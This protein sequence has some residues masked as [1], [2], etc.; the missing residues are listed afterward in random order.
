M[1]Q[2]N[3]RRRMEEIRKRVHQQTDT[4]FADFDESTKSGLL[5]ELEKAMVTAAIREEKLRAAQERPKVI[6]MTDID[7]TEQEKEPL[8]E[9]VKVSKTETPDKEAIPETDP[10]PANSGHRGIRRR[11]WS[12]KGSF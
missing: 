12:F 8:E 9:T 3:E 11:T 5:E 6:K 10:A 1:K 7:R 2:E 4:L